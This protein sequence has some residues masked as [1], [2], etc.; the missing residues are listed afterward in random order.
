MK[1]SVVT[2]PQVL[3]VEVNPYILPPVTFIDM[4]VKSHLPRPVPYR[5]N[6]YRYSRRGRDFWGCSIQSAWNIVKN[7]GYEL[8]HFRFSD[9]VFILGAQTTQL[10]DDS[11]MI[12]QFLFGHFW[13]RRYAAL[14][15]TMVNRIEYGYGMFYM[16]RK[17]KT[18]LQIQEFLSTIVKLYS[19]TWLQRPL[20]VEVGISDVYKIRVSQGVD[21]YLRSYSH[22]SKNGAVWNLLNTTYYSNHP[23]G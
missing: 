19:K 4:C 13:S 9:A 22:F 7:Y 21:S 10:M 17:L 23:F 15:Y 14:M 11:N 1:S 5:S 12:R 18:Q 20:F 3:Q 8:L 16:L 6:G 2:L